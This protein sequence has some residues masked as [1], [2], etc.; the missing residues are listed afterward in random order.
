MKAHFDFTQS[1]IAKKVV[2]KGYNRVSTLTNI[3]CLID[4]VV[5][6]SR[7]TL[8]THSENSTLSCCFKI[9]WPRLEWVVRVM[10][11]L[12]EVK[13]VVC[14]VRST[15]GRRSRSRGRHIEDT[16]LCEVLLHF[17]FTF[18]HR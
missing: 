6:L 11:L 18:L 7:D 9:H 8:T 15:T 2:K 14:T 3:R 10:Y 16:L 1:M 12:G 5:Y 17:L 4:E 13:G